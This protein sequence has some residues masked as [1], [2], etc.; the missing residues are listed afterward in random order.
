MHGVHYYGFE[1]GTQP[2]LNTDP[3]RLYGQT[4]TPGDKINGFDSGNSRTSYILA[5][6]GDYLTYV[7]RFGVDLLFQSSPGKKPQQGNLFQQRPSW[8]LAFGYVS[9][10][11]GLFSASSPGTGWDIQPKKIIR[12]NG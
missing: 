5:D 7:G 10:F 8:Y 3:V 11:G 1:N 12:N 6:P 2:E 9:E 4:L